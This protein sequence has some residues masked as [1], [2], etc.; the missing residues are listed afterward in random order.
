MPQYTRWRHACRQHAYSSSYNLQYADVGHFRGK[1]SQDTVPGCPNT[2]EGGTYA[3]N[4]RTAIAMTSD[5]QMLVTS[6][7]G[8][9][10]IQYRDAPIHPMASRRPH[11]WARYPGIQYHGAPDVARQH[12]HRG[13]FACCTQMLVTSTVRYRR[14]R[15]RDAPIHPM[16]TR[17]PPTCVQL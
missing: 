2:P 1:V 16:A 15:F 13:A 5:T 3:A 14:I 4:M 9:L 8:Y 17:M 7:V 10:G 12:A 11:R 6:T